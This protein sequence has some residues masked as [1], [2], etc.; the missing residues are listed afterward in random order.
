MAWFCSI[1]VTTMKIRDTGSVEIVVC[2]VVRRG[3][4]DL[5]RSRSEAGRTPRVAPFARIALQVCRA[6]LPCYRSRFSKHQFNQP[7]LL[8]I[9][10]RA[11]F[12]DSV[13]FSATAGRPG[14]RLCGGRDGAE[15]ARH[16]QKRT[17]ADPRGGRRD[18]LG[19]GSRQHILRAADA[20]S[21]TETAAVAALAEV[22]GRRGF[23]SAVRVVAVGASR[24]MER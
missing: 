8:A 16:E 19:A 4:L 14:H 15:A 6:A 21:R 24:P 13:S 11:R 9:G 20:S 7:Q 10:E 5:S 2:Y 12:H 18:G 23:G 22:G 3:G 1:L 17:A